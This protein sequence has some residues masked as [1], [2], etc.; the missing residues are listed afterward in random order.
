MGISSR[1]AAALTRLTF[2]VVVPGSLEVSPRVVPSLHVFTIIRFVLLHHQTGTRKWVES[3][4]LDIVK[5]WR[6]WTSSVDGQV[7]GWTQARPTSSAP[8]MLIDRHMCYSSSVLQWLLLLLRD[9][10][11]SH[12]TVDID[13]PAVVVALGRA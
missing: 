12:C 4:G 8:A 2:T 13:L 7:A 10:S 3:L 1:A 11:I 9:S 5:E 6:P